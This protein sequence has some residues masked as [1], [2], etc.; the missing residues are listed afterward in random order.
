MSTPHSRHT[1]ALVKTAEDDFLFDCYDT[2]VVEARAGAVAAA[3]VHSAPD[4]ASDEVR[5]ICPPSMHR[6][7]FRACGTLKSVEIQTLHTAFFRPGCTIQSL[8][9]VLFFVLSWRNSDG[10]DWVSKVDEPLTRG[11]KFL[12]VEARTGKDGLRWVRRLGQSGSGHECWVAVFSQAG[13][14]PSPTIP[15]LQILP[16]SRSCLLFCNLTG[17]N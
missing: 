8:L 3:S 13:A 14:V 17:L 5:Q 1:P 9:A 4:Y 2:Y 6:T 15:S 11:D 7:S 16:L 12:A 10:R